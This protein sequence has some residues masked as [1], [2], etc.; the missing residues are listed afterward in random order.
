MLEE[1]SQRTTAKQR[2]TGR[3][4]HRQLREGGY[5][6]GLTLVLFELRE[7][8]RRR[9]EV[10]VP[11]VHRPAESAQVDIFE[12]RVDLAGERRPV[13]LLLFRLMHSGRD[14]VQL[15]ERQDQL[16]FLDGHVRPSPTSAACPGELSTTTSGRRCGGCSSP[17]A[18]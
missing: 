14:Y 4:L 1:G 18:G 3:R 17:V 15:Y 8:R 9:A 7:W 12:V 13:W 2:I 16:A 11:L 5:E 10:Y 6:V